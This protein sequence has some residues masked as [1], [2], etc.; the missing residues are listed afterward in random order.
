MVT[1]WSVNDQTA[2]YLVAD[3]MR[4]VHGGDGINQALREA[5]LSMLDGAG[6]TFPAALAH[7]FYWGP[8]ALI[9]DGGV[10]KV[11]SASLASPGKPNL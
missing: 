6:T 9:G 1:H 10:N 5:Q 7:P 4:R 3:S 11:S 2:A 8:F